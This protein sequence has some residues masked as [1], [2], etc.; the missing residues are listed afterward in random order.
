MAMAP[1]FPIASWLEHLGCGKH[2]L[3]FSFSWRWFGHL[4]PHHNLQN[5]YTLKRWGKG[6]I[7]LTFVLLH[8]C[9]SYIFHSCFTLCLEA[10]DSPYIP[11]TNAAMLNMQSSAGSNPKYQHRT[12]REKQNE[13]ILF[14]SAC[15]PSGANGFFQVSKHWDG[16]LYKYFR[17]FFA[18][19][20]CDDGTHWKARP[21]IKWT[22]RQSLQK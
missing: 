10:S 21:A 14:L 8:A 5:W 1:L 2:L 9:Y 15:V 17:D 19:L 20:V 22:L 3:R 4:P 18:N 13:E 16:R 12:H 7:L 11:Y 6:K